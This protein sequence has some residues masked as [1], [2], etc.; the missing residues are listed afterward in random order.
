MEIRKKLAQG[1]TENLRRNDRYAPLNTI[2]RKT[3]KGNQ[4]RR[5]DKKNQ[6]ILKGNSTVAHGMR[7]RPRSTDKQD[8][9]Q[10]HGRKTYKLIEHDPEDRGSK[11]RESSYER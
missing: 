4:E 1:T 6:K 5:L 8:R 9:R 3:A 2:Q 11:L 7:R 10:L